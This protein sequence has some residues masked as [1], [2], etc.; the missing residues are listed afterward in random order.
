MKM[1]EKT[2]IPRC[3]FSVESQGTPEQE[4]DCGEPSVAIWKWDDGQSMYVCERHD[5]EMDEILYEEMVI[6]K[7]KG[8]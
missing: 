7:S 8:E 2:T 6:K 1:P 4:M 5:D 3:S